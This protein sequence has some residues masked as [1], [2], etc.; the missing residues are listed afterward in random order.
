MRRRKTAA[1]R[2]GISI[3]WDVDDVRSCRY[4][5]YASPAVYDCSDS[6]FAVHRSKPRHAVSEHPW[7]PYSDQLGT[8]DSSDLVVWE[9]KQ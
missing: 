7:E 8:C 4:Q 6:Y 5:N 1:E 3:G 2:I 9:C